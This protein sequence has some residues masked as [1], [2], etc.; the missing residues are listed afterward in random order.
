MHVNSNTFVITEIYIML[1]VYFLSGVLVLIRQATVEELEDPRSPY[2]KKQ[3]RVGSRREY[4]SI[5][6][7]E[8]KL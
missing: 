3:L 5:C 8:I 2:I 7:M 1:I 4:A 6:F